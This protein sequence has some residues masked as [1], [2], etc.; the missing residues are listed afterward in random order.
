MLSVPAL[1][2]NFLI[3]PPGSPPVGWEQ[4]LEEA[5]NS[6]TLA[7]DPD[8]GEATAWGDE[9]AR[10]LRFLSVSS[11]GDDDDGTEVQP[12]PSRRRPNP[13]DSD[14]D[15][16]EEPTTSVVLG[17][18]SVGEAVRPAV[19]V[20]TPAA[21]AASAPGSDGATPPPGA[22]KI[23]AVKATIE[24]LLGRK[25]SFSGLERPKLDAPEAETPRFG[26]T[27]L[28]GS[29]PGGARITPTARPP[30]ASEDEFVQ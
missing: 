1:S 28:G 17:P 15:E 21:A 11:G 9:L 12:V 2:R 20:S 13:L 25:R 24:S 23:T 18:H 5:P 16:D 8:Q 26:G 14:E 22:A 27:L 10:A 30:T 3:S 7:D 19:T 4:T 29:Q 6:Q